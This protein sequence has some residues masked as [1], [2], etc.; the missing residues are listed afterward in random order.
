MKHIPYLDGW[1]G[2]AIIFVLL[3][4]FLGLDFC[5]RTGVD[6]FF[7]LSGFLMSRILFIE[8]MPLGVFYNH[9]IARI[10]PVL[11]LYLLVM[12]IIGWIYIR[13][14]DINDVIY[15]LL[16]LR[17]YVGGEIRAAPIPIG[18]LWS[19]NIEEHSYLLLSIIAFTCIG[20]SR[21]SPM[22]ALTAC[23]FFSASFYVVY[24]HFPPSADHY[25]GF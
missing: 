24:K 11:Y 14:F 15:S 6:L 12:G 19:L 13:D 1:R 17:T 22:A 18:H 5:G 20:R 23:A 21:L 16:F 10:I 4:H 9:R 8:K 2:I 25:H 7:V 3:E